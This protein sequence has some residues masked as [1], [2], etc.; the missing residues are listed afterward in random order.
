MRAVGVNGAEA[1]RCSPVRASGP[2]R[3]DSRGSY[4]YY[5]TSTTRTTANT[6]LF[7][8]FRDA[9]PPVPDEQRAAMLRYLE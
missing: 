9:R 7:V 2:S 5:D 4:S 6:T 8:S 3:P 1:R